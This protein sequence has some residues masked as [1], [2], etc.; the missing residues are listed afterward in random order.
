VHSYITAMLLGMWLTDLA[1]R[2]LFEG[3]TRRDFV[4]LLAVPGLVLLGFWQAGLFVVGPGMVKSGF[5]KYRM[6]LLS[7]VDPSGWSYV[8]KDLPEGPG[9][10]EGF[11]YLG[12]GAIALSLA[13]LPGLKRAW[14]VL[15]AKR[16]YWPL[17]LLLLSLTLFALSNR[18]GFASFGFD[19]PLPQGAIDRANTLRGSG[20]MFWP[21]FYVILWAILRAVIKRY[22]AKL[23]AGMLCGALLLQAVDT[24]AGWLPIRKSMEPMGSTWS[25][26]LKSAFWA[27]VP[28]KYR[29]IHMVVPKN[30][31]PGYEVFAYFAATHGMAT[32][33]FYAARVDDAKLK[34]ATQRA[35]SAVR[36]GEYDADT[37][38]VLDPKFVR[39]AQRKLDPTCD[40][41]ERID[42]FWIVAPGFRCRAESKHPLE[43]KP[44]D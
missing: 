37:L 2:F 20:R 33:A 29:R 36:R 25:S 35:L 38:Y 30:Q 26:P 18:V 27:S 4:Q 13:A 12:L 24:S 32:D 11:N 7:L 1:R 17:L 5:G 3:R 21:V 9:D 22:P 19:I 15:R 43:T 44:S 8:L 42:G 16:H 10:H 31:K 6:N 34:A 41:L 23:A 39:T 28:E 14:P 40:I